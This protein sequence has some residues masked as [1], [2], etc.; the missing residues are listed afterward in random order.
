M[1]TEVSA[2][3]ALPIT[4]GN[5]FRELGG[6]QSMNG[7]HIKYHKVLRSGRLAPLSQQDLTYLDQYGTRFDVDLRSADEVKEA[8]DKVPANATYKYLPVFNYDQTQNSLTLQELENE[9]QGNPNHGHEHMKLVY[10]NMIAEPHAKQSYHQFFEILLANAKDGAATL[11]HCTAG[12]DRTGMAAVFFMAALGID[13][14]TIKTDY[15]LTNKIAAPH[16]NARLNE[17]KAQHASA[18]TIANIRSLH[19]VHADYLAAAMAQVKRE[20]G[21]LN[22]YLHE[23]LQLTDHDLQELRK[24]Y[25]TD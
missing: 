15:L 18:D 13:Q 20:S 16:I 8:P 23:G 3:R 4:T 10:H 12:K 7:Q 5:N 17:L 24:I 22:N 9:Y 14:E 1:T 25:L 11:F 6:Y 19:S 21:D 2:L